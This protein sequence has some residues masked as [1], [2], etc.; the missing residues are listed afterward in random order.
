MDGTRFDRWTRAWGATRSR[1]G[2][3][4]LLVAATAGAALGLPAG[5]AAADHKAYGA[6]CTCPPD[7]TTCGGHCAAGLVCTATRNGTRCRCKP[8]T[9]RCA[10]AC[11]NT[12]TDPD[13][14]GG[15]PG[16]AC[17]AA[18]TNGTRVC[19]NGACGSRCTPGF[20]RCRGGCV[21]L[22]TVAHCAA[23]GDACAAGD[24]CSTAV[25]TEGTCG[26]TPNGCTR[27]TSASPQCFWMDC[28][29]SP[30]C[31]V[32]AS[33]L[34]IDA[35]NEASC[36]AWDCCDGGGCQDGGGGCFKWSTTSC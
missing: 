14:C 21:E 7:R 32:P 4:R 8:P 27:H 2:A 16:V 30:C 5:R 20:T 23:C 31:W 11:V 1:R 15:C 19:R 10:G 33:L 6:P 36:E 12:L 28:D 25:C 3:L 18:P 35:R 34:G 26:T 17:P 24:A 22:G 29:S 9:V 13:H